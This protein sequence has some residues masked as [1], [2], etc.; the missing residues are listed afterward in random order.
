MFG[1]FVEG[2]GRLGASMLASLI[3]VL[4]LG[5]PIAFGIWLGKRSARTWLGVACGF[6]VLAL[7]AAMPWPSAD[8]LRRKAC[9]RPRYNDCI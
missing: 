1:A 3:M 4:S 9:D 8:V 2:L 5:G 6:F 7:L